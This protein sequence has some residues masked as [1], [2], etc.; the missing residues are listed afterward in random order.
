MYNKPNKFSIDYYKQSKKKEEQKKKEN[1]YVTISYIMKSILNDNF[2][3]CGYSNKD[4]RI[5]YRTN[6]GN[7]KVNGE[8]A[9]CS[10]SNENLYDYVWHT[11]PKVSKYMPSKEDIWKIFKHNKISSKIFTRY[12]YWKLTLTYEGKKKKPNPNERIKK[13]YIL[14]KYEEKYKEEIRKIKDVFYFTTNK[15]KSWNKEAVDKYKKEINELLK[16]KKDFPTDKES[17]NKH[18]KFEIVF[19]NYKKK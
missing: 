1:S 16:S 11:H 14:K 2:E 6:K 5:Y 9:S 18:Y 10:I 15:G 13:E 3:I 17:I 12:G 19:Y 4:Q 7:P 8:R